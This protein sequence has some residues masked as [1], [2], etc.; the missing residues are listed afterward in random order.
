MRTPGCGSPDF[1]WVH[2]VEARTTLETLSA[3]G[4]IGAFHPIPK[5]AAGIAKCGAV[6]ITRPREA[7]VLLERKE[8]CVTFLTDHRNNLLAGLSAAVREYDAE[9]LIVVNARAMQ[10]QLMSNEAGH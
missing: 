4:L 2:S 1:R 7:G 5:S 6:W 3:Q 9:G 8:A 10:S